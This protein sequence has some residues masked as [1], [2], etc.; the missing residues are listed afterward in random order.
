M[1]MFSGLIACFPFE[2]GIETLTGHQPASL[3]A[4]HLHKLSNERIVMMFGEQTMEIN[5][6]SSRL[7]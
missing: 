2:A 5:E 3:Y 1:E 4:R 6:S 7:V